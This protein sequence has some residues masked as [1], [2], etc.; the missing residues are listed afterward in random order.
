MEASAG[1]AAKSV[2]RV[3]VVAERFGGCYSCRYFGER[4]DPAVW[5]AFPNGEHLRSQAERGPGNDDE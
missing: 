4:V 3:I 2:Y 5:C 1:T